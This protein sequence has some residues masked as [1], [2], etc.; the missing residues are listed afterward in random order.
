MA[1]QTGDTG[2]A[3]GR[4]TQSEHD[5]KP[6]APGYTPRASTEQHGDTTP[7]SLQQEPGPLTQQTDPVEGAPRPDLPGAERAQT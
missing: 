4:V 5:L 1:E 3:G 7:E 6:G 2:A